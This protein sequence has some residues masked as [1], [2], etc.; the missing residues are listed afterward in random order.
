L[1]ASE[2]FMRSRSSGPVRGLST[3]VRSARRP[4]SGHRP[5][6]STVEERAWSRPGGVRTSGAGPAGPVLRH[7]QRP[8]HARRLLVLFAESLLRFRWRRALRSGSSGRRGWTGTR[9]RSCRRGSRRGARRSGFAG[10]RRAASVVGPCR[11]RWRWR[12]SGSRRGRRGRTGRPLR[13]GTGRGSVTG[14]RPGLGVGRSR[15]AARGRRCTWCWPRRS[16]RRAGPPRQVPERVLRRHSG[17]L[18]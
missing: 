3:E 13:R 4:D 14:G 1:S 11:G 17:R 12:R 16:R 2:S 5:V 18:A 10:G 7:A 8:S 6:C 15:V 9:R